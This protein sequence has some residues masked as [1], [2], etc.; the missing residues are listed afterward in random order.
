MGAGF[1]CMNHLTLPSYLPSKNKR[2]ARRGRCTRFAR[3]LLFHINHQLSTGAG[4]PSKRL[5][6]TFCRSRS[7]C[8]ATTSHYQTLYSERVSIFEIQQRAIVCEVR[9]LFNNFRQAG[10]KISQREHLSSLVQLMA[11]FAFGFSLL[12]FILNSSPIR[13]RNYRLVSFTE[14]LALT[15]ALQRSGVASKKKHSG[16][17]AGAA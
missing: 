11:T 17:M 5:H 15:P 4:S 12:P 2:F 14:D 6:P 7:K 13:T 16:K 1:F 3:R 10:S 9:R 8:K